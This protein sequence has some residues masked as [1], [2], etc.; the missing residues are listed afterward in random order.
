MAGLPPEGIEPV[1]KLSKC[2]MKIHAVTLGFLRAA[3]GNAPG[4]APPTPLFPGKAVS[5]GA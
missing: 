2:E 4:L 1:G 5:S 3:A